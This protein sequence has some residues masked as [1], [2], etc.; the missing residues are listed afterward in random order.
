MLVIHSTTPSVSRKF[1]YIYVQGRLQRPR[2]VSL[3][4]KKGSVTNV[5]PTPAPEATPA[6]WIGGKIILELYLIPYAQIN[7]KGVKEGNMKTIKTK[8]KLVPDHGFSKPGTE[9]NSQCSVIK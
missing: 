6:G 7:P 4:Q 3:R 5:Q 1:M 8:G 9:T 2:G